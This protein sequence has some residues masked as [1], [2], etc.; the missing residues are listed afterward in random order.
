VTPDDIAED[1]L[2]VLGLVDRLED[3]VDRRRP[4]LLPGLDQLDQFVHDR[5]RLGNADVVAGERQ[6]VPAE[7]DVDLEPFAEGVEDAVADRGELG[8]YVVRDVEDLLGQA[9]FSFTS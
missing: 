2:H 1:V 6:P 9:S 7:Q 8:G 5:A 3:G 4:D